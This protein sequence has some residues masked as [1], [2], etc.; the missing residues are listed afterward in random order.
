MSRGK[1]I[2]LTAIITAIIAAL[3]IIGTTV[4]N[5]LYSAGEKV[6]LNYSDLI[7]D[8]S[9]LC[10]EH[11]QR[12]WSDG[13]QYTVTSRI[14]IEGK[15]ST[16]QSGKSVDSWH[17]AKL[18]YILQRDKG[19]GPT[20]QFEVQQAI[21]NYITEW[22]HEVGHKHNGL[23]WNFATGSKG[24]YHTNLEDEAANYADNLG[25]N[26][27][28]NNSDESKIK[29]KA[30][31]NG[32]QTDLLVGP[33][34][35]EFSGKLTDV[36]LSDNKGKTISPKEYAKYTG[37]DL[38]KLGLS[39]IKSGESFYIII[40]SNSG[41]AVINNIKAT[42]S[43][44]VKVADIAFL[45]C[46]SEDW[47]N[48]IQYNHSEKQLN[49]D[50]DWDV[51]IPLL[52][53]ISGYV[54]EDIWGGKN[55]EFD[56]VYHGKDYKVG[57]ETYDG[58]DVLV[59][60]LTVK[61]K[62][63]NGNVIKNN[64]GQEATAKTDSNGSYK[65]TD[66][67]ISDL[68]G[69]YVEFEYD[70][71]KYTSVKALVGDDNSINSKAGEVV[72][73]RK[74]LNTAFTEIT[75]KD[76]ISDR[77]HGYSRN[78]NGKTTGTINYKEDK[79]NWR[80]VYE[81]STYNTNL[82]ADTNVTSYSIEEQFKDEKYVENE[83]GTLEIKYINLGI[84]QRYQPTISLT[85]DINNVEVTV[86][87]YEHN[88]IYATRNAHRENT[89]AFNIG[90]RFG[91]NND[92]YTRA[93]Y[94]SDVKYSQGLAKDNPN[95]LRVYVTY[96]IVVHNNSTSTGGLSVTANE[97]VNYYDKEYT[98]VDS[99]VGDN[100]DNKITWNTTS[101]YGQSYN[102]GKYVGAY[103]T[104]LAGQKIAAEQNAQT[105]YI[106]FQVSDN[107]VLGLLNNTS[108]LENVTELYAYSTYYGS[109]KEGCKAG[110]IYAGVDAIETRMEANDLGEENGVKPIDSA[111][112][113]ATPGDV[114]TYEADT[115]RAPSLLLEAKGVREIEGTVF[116]DKT[117]DTLQSEK[118]RLGNGIYDNGENT[119]SGVKVELLSATDG[120]VATIYPPANEDANKDGVEVSTAET[121]IDAV[122]ESTGANGYYIF[123]GVE[124]GKYLIRYTYANGTTKICDT[125]GKEIKDITVQDY[126]STIITS[127]VIKRAFE[128]NAAVEKDWYKQKEANR[129][130]DA[131]DN[132]DQR[133]AIDNEMMN[134]NGSTVPTI[135]SIDANSPEFNIGVE[136][137]TIYSASTG[138]AYT[139]KISDL[140]FG[141]VRRPMQS[142]D[143]DK[144]VSHI[145]VTLPNEQVLID[146]DVDVAKGIAPKYVT[147][148]GDKIYITIDSELLRGSHIELAYN[149]T[150]TNTSEQDYRN[151]SYYYYG[152]DKSNPVQ[153]SK[154]TL[155][156]FVDREIT[157]NEIP[158]KTW[159]VTDLANEGL[160]LT[161]EEKEKLLKE[162]STVV[163][164]EAL[165]DKA[166]SAGES[167]T[168]KIN[169]EKILSTD[170]DLSYENNG[171]I[172]SISK[173][174]GSSMITTLGSY[175][176][177]LT[178]QVDAMPTESDEDKAETVTIIPPTGEVDNTVMYVTIGA[179]SLAM[180]GT[181][182]YVIRRIVKL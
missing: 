44:T 149:L 52:I 57:N 81:S 113:N 10:I 18:A 89:T 126:K 29:V 157:L 87:G 78:E 179:I 19:V 43:S 145:K 66:I 33:F 39:D 135:T 181:G 31:K 182:T 141:I 68:E 5:G 122:I 110:D 45:N 11:H 86:N 116:E 168:T 7:N 160:V 22:M 65:F 95:K 146:G 64:N 129:Y 162:F 172:V 178:A 77:T 12:M 121:G 112:G 94:P 144:T 154:A 127:E 90:V 125:T 103:S 101:K 32:D 104:G 120:S 176:T 58:K 80:S 132:Y 137:E 99:W 48:L 107:A 53:N 47:Q 49:A 93:I 13:R 42:A 128:D 136:Y 84:V 118:E 117:A 166:I 98:I 152:Q 4:V 67:L 20:S 50:G 63:K 169:V 88:Y 41:M 111:P 105:V 79:S 138:Q 21:W 56:N 92:K 85:Q 142:A 102:D 106:K 96:A 167:S 75:N 161:P 177:L 173:T 3:A 109:D 114:S 40:P 159:S 23:N 34:K 124:P 46:S 36:K 119:M 83:D 24:D 30:Y 150:L 71:L 15:T 51:T 82:S 76:T 143:L 147:I 97:L 175:A 37:S 156:D 130:S 35:F 165:P 123:K 170:G 2:K 38:N 28:S 164:A 74:A 62:D 69:C 9:L 155:M 72:S 153:I 91:T 26:K 100:Q 61:L 140:D 158:G 133:E 59:A 55:N 174:G 134:V 17:N 148:A 27:I 14:H 180:L 115:N 60:G 171:E 6:W 25:E 54:W 16:D 108:T 8:T 70:G 139:Y 1:K 73:Q 163:T 151:K 131:I